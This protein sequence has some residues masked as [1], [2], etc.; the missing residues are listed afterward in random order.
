MFTNMLY[1]I[2]YK[3]FQPSCW[4]S[5]VFHTIQ[6]YTYSQW[7]EHNTFVHQATLSGTSANH[8]YSY[9][10]Q[11]T[12][13]YNSSSSIGFHKNAVTKTKQEDM[14]VALEYLWL[15]LVPESVA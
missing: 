14:F 1:S 7:I 3:P 10:T 2:H 5:T 11:I 12:E 6:E 4:I 15:A 13:A 8:R 9:A